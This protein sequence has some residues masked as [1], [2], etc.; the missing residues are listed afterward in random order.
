[1]EINTGSQADY[2]DRV[3]ASNSTSFLDQHA[4][5]GRAL[6][7]FAPSQL[8]LHTQKNGREDYFPNWSESTDNPL[9]F[10]TMYKGIG[11]AVLVGLDFCHQ[12]VKEDPQALGR[13]DVLCN[14][15]RLNFLSM[16]DG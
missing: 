11:D 3:R 6:L 12:I 4:S 13:I 2:I 10:V 5:Q 1:M 7:D 8:E 15:S 9:Y 16:I 14:G